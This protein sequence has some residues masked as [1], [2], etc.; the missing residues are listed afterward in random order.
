MSL[1]ESEKMVRKLERFQLRSIAQIECTDIAFGDFTVFV[2]PQASGKSILLQF[3]K[4]VL[5]TGYIHDQL[6]KHGID[7]D[8]DYLQFLDVYLGQGMHRIWHAEKS[9]ILCNGKSIAIETL[10]TPHRRSAV[11]RVFYIPAQRVPLTRKYTIVP[12]AIGIP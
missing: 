4:L 12:M 8:S 5:D 6:R 11:S 9:E 2:G 1:I 7:W 3:V 10:A